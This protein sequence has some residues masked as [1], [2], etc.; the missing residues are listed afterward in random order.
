MRICLE[1]PCPD[2]HPENLVRV[3]LLERIEREWPHR[4]EREWPHRIDRE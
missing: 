1:W 2:G 4:I 3:F